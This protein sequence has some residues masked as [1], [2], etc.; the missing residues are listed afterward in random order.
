M[1]ELVVTMMQRSQAHAF[2]SLPSPTKNQNNAEKESATQA[3]YMPAWQKEGR[4]ANVVDTSCLKYLEPIK[5]PHF[6]AP[7]AGLPKFET[8]IQE[9]S[10]I[11]QTRTN[12]AAGGTMTITAGHRCFA[13]EFISQSTI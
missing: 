3:P 7:S 6:S 8:Q 13:S 10:K 2:F 9:R 5:M 1:S 4:G 11:M 12:Q